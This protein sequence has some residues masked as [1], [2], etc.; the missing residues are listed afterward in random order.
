MAHNSRVEDSDLS[1]LGDVI[2]AKH[3]PQIAVEYLRIPIA[4]VESFQAGAREDVEIFKLKCLEFWRNRN[5]TD[6]ARS[7]LYT[8]LKQASKS[9]LLDSDCIKFLIEDEEHSTEGIVKP[10]FKLFLFNKN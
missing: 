4:K 9:G 3:M 1:R 6:D 10:K 2:S 7:K 5:E 8:I